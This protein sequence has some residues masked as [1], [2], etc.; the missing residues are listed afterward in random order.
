MKIPAHPQ[1]IHTT[2]RLCMLKWNQSYQS[3]LCHTWWAFPYCDP[4]AMKINNFWTFFCSFITSSSY[5][6]IDSSCIYC[7]DTCKCCV[8]VAGTVQTES[9]SHNIQNILFSSANEMLTDFSFCILLV[10]CVKNLTLMEPGE[11]KAKD[12]VLLLSASS[13]SPSAS[14]NS[15]LWKNT[16]YLNKK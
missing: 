3:K 9:C 1:E 8:E 7:I 14:K 4:A 6:S 13:D 2:L 16:L 15:K 11:I 10:I 5:G 12:F